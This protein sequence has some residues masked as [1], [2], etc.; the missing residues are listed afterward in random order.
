MSCN[1]SDL[2]VSLSA[3]KFYVDDLIVMGALSLIKGQLLPDLP[4]SRG[5][6]AEGLGRVLPSNFSHLLL[7]SS[8][9]DWSS[10]VTRGEAASITAKLTGVGADARDPKSSADAMVRDSFL[11]PIN[12]GSAPNLPLTRVEMVNLLWH[13]AR[14]VLAQHSDLVLRSTP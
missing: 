9:S 8:T 2:P 14:S 12:G 10:V 11:R 7:K 4:V 13:T 6:L 3:T 5:M 1:I